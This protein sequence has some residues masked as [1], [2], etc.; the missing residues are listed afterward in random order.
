[1]FPHLKWVMSNTSGTSNNLSNLSD[2]HE[3][4]MIDAVFLKEIGNHTFIEHCGLTTVLILILYFE[5][6]SSYIIQHIYDFYHIPVQMISLTQS[7]L[8]L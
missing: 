2:Q 5:I 1:M 6:I 3:D 4:T 8:R 7:S